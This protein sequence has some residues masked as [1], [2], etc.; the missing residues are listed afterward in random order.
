MWYYAAKVR[1]PDPPSQLIHHLYREPEKKLFNLCMNNLWSKKWEIIVCE[2]EK[3]D[4]L[5]A[6]CHAEI[7]D[8]ISSNKKN[9][10]M[11]LY[12]VNTDSVY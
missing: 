10:R 12:H 11:L 9:Y 5:C 6:N 7:E 2:F 4:L 3:C 8:K 1:L